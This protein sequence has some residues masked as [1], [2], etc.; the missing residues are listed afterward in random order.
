MV[1]FL[2]IIFW[3]KFGFIYSIIIII[4]III[5]RTYYWNIDFF[6]YDFTFYQAKAEILPI[7]RHECFLPNLSNLS[8]ITHPSFNYVISNTLNSV[9]KT[10]EAALTLSKLARKY[11][12]CRHVLAANLRY[13]LYKCLFSQ[14]QRQTAP[15]C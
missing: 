6:C 1:Q 5:I 11:L 14:S 3:L 9:L 4:I 10:S 7:W 12:K 2:N 15:T 13:F 8:S